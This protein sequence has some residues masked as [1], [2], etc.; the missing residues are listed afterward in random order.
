MTQY[1]LAEIL[2]DSL[3]SKLMVLPDETIIYPGHG[4]GSACGKN[5]SKETV[6]TLGE[7]KQTNYALR[8][9]MSKAEFVNNPDA[10]VTDQE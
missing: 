9:D 10:P 6:G 3:R 7:Q 4:A 5:M 8:A 1:Q 2:Y